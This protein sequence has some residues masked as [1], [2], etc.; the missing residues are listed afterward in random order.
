GVVGCDTLTNILGYTPANG[1]NYVAKA[2]DTM[3]GALNLPSNGLAVGTNQFVMS[4]GN[5][6]IGTASPDNI[7]TIEKSANSV[8]WQRM[9]NSNAG[10]SASIGILFGGDG[11]TGQSAI[12]Q[13]SNAN[14]ALGGIGSLN[15]GNYGA[16]GVGF[17]TNGVQRALIDYQGQVGIGTTGPGRKLDVNGTIASTG[18]DAPY[19]SNAWIRNF[20]ASHGGAIVWPIGAGD[21]SWG[22]GKSNNPSK[23][24]IFNSTVNDNSAAANYV[25]TMENSGNV[26]IGTTSPNVTLD[27]GS[28]TDALRLPAGTTAQR[29]G[30]SANGDLRYNSTSSQME[31]YVAGS[32]T[33]LLTTGQSRGFSV[34]N[35]VHV[36]TGTVNWAGVLYN[37]GNYTPANGRYTATVSGLY[38]LCTSGISYSLATYARWYIQINGVNK[39]TECRTGAVGGDYGSCGVCTT[40]FMNAGDYATVNVTNDGIYSGYGGFSGVMISGSTVASG[41]SGTANYIPQWTSS[42]ALGNSPIAVSGSNVGVGTSSPGVKLDVSGTV[43]ANVAEG[44]N[45]LSLLNSANGGSWNFRL[46]GDGSTANNLYLDS[47]NLGG[48]ALTIRSNGNIGI[49]TTAPTQK[50][51]VYGTAKIDSIMGGEING[52]GNFHLDARGGGATYLN[53]S[54]GSGGVYIMNGAMGYGSI[55]AG[56]FT[57]NSDKTLK[58]NIEPIKNSLDL[59]NQMNGVKFN[60]INP[61]E[62]P[63]RQVGVIAQD[64]QKV[65]PELVTTNKE[66]GRLAV[67]Y[68][69]L[70][71]PLIEAVKELY[72]KLT[73]TQTEV[74]AMKREL[75]NVK[76]E[77]KTLSEQNKA[78]KALVCL[79]HPKA[80]VCKK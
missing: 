16:A 65:L 6:G 5:I 55:Y 37:D 68:P 18:S 73:G 11:S 71:A 20:E 43:R 42:T 21:R 7:L 24:F 57:V 19:T 72:Q 23:F 60:W 77:V 69:A 66:T 51:H 38:Y 44:S 74:A 61:K 47:S 15:I 62:S 13:N 35:S 34:Y 41:G 29:P 12:V 17:F 32:W 64:V 22:I 40:A 4:G 25:M 46:Q 33:S 76:D 45:A 48:N 70:V 9:R 26:G 63:D 49:G 53:W 30:S 75:A 56:A 78:L 52:A 50:L 1:T 36:G 58:K 31:A 3:T 59:V 8:V 39:S 79:D 80:D 28:K 67:N 54:S 27:L 10:S 2:G 14:S